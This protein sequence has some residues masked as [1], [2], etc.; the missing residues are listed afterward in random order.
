MTSSRRYGP[1]VQNQFNLAGRRLG[2]DLAGLFEDNE[3]G[4]SQFGDLTP[5][6]RVSSTARGR[7]HALSMKPQQL[8]PVT[9]EFSLTPETGSTTSV[10]PGGSPVQPTPMPVSP[11]MLKEYFGEVGGVGVRDIGESGFG[12][13]DYNAAIDAGYDPES[14]KKYVMENQ[15]NFTNIGPGARET[16]G[17]TDYVSTAPGAF[18]YAEYG[19]SGFGM[20]DVEALKAKGVPYARMKKLAEQAP[21]IGAG[22]AQYF[23]MAQTT[24]PEPDPVNY[25]RP[26]GPGTTPVTGFGLGRG[27]GT[28][29]AYEAFGGAGFGMK[30]VAALASKGAS[31]AD[32]Q[33]I[34]KKASN[35]GPEARKLLG[36]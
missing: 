25:E 15:Y 13:K 32:M 11:P 23:D 30:D 26:S 35:I 33:R 31:T 10:I 16:L 3:D 4:T 17:I 6:L 22:A 5:G 12:M 1:A 19:E 20:K 21:R 27:D 34:A 2:L 28:G 14:I 9:T 24:A 7:G 29:F 18:D 8:D 36:L